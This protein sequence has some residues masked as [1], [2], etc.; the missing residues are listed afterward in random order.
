MIN[1]KEQEKKNKAYAAGTAVNLMHLL[2]ELDR[3][4]NTSTEQS[5]LNAVTQEMDQFISACGEAK[6]YEEARLFGEFK[7]SIVKINTDKKT[8][9]KDIRLRAAQVAQIK[10]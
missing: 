10:F 3:Y 7:N 4:S 9:I 2:S 5:C 6:L 1:D 8:L